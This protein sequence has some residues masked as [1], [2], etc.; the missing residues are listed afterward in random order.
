MPTQNPIPTVTIQEAS[1]NLKKINP[2]MYTNTPKSATG[3]VPYLSAQIP[4][5][6]WVAPHTIF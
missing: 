3:R 2:M 5:T 1:A 4:T 6:G